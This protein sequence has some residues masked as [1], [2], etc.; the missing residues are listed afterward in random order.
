[1]PHLDFIDNVREYANRIRAFR[2]SI[3]ETLVLIETEYQALHLSVQEAITSY[4]RTSRYLLG[5]QDWTILERNAGPRHLIV[6]PPPEYR[7]QLQLLG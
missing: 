3:L 5:N 2:D 6:G 4:I 1:V 7:L